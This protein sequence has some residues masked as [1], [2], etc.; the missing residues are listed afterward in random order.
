[1]KIRLAGINAPELDRPYGVKS[2]YE[3]VN[4]ALSD[5]LDAQAANP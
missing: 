1:M 5:K 2:K 4:M 3:M